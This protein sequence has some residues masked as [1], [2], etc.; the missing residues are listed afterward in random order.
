MLGMLL[1]TGPGALAARNSYAT[2]A[3]PL[4]TPVGYQSV[5]YRGAIPCADC[6]G[7]D[8]IVTL[9]S[10]DDASVNGTYTLRQIYLGRDVAPFE[11][12]GVFNVSRLVTANLDM[13]VLALNPLD[14]TM[15]M[16]FERI[17]TA[18]I[19]LLDMNK[20]PIVSS[21]NFTLDREEKIG[22]ANPASVHCAKLGGKTQLHA[23]RMGNAYGM[24]VFP[25]GQECEEWAL[26][27][28]QLCRPYIDAH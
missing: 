19:R 1:G 22:M 11:S 14:R 21:L 12:T 13:Q 27:N 18:Q 15:P 7:I 6:E 16:Y 23:D 24:C 5:T 8:M 26:F 3:G 4:V 10:R 28:R 25:D 9:E 2:P 17:S 20:R